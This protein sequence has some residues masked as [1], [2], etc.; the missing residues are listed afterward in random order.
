MKRTI[1]LTLLLSLAINVSVSAQSYSQVTKTGKCGKDVEWTLT[2][3]T[4]MI[5][6]A[7]TKLQL[8]EIADYD[9]ERAVAPWVKQKLK[10]TKVIIGRDIKRIGSCAFANCDELLT[11]EFE[12]VRLAEIGWGAFYNCR[13]LYQIS[14]PVLIKKIE[15]VAFANCSSIKSVKIPSLAYVEDNAFASCTNLSS[16]DI[17]SDVFLGNNVF[18]TEVEENG[19]MT[20]KMYNKDIINLPSNVNVDNCMEFGLSPNAVAVAKKRKNHS[21]EEE[22][23]RKSDVDLLIP[24][25]LKTRNDTYALVIGNQNYRFVPEVPFAINDALTFVQYCKTTLGIPS[26]NI[27]YCEDATKHMILELELE[28]WLKKDVPDKENKKLIV[29]YAG[30]GVPDINDNNKAYLLPTDVYGTKAYLGISLDDFYSKIGKMGFKVVTI[31]LDACFSGVN[32]NNEGL[33]G[34]RAVEIEAQ[35][36]RPTE[37]NLIVFSAAHGNETAQG[38]QEQGHGLFTYYL[39]KELKDSRGEISYGKLAQNLKKN[40]ST[41]APFLN[42]RKKQTPTTY[43]S[44]GAGSWQ[45]DA[46]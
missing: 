32:R 31:F 25:G 11:V 37:G 46:F 42:L 27:H 6:K 40:V 39:L 29:Y 23:L 18:V 34:E 7:S 38:F 33:A 4:L 24:E 21:D 2:G 36:S 14:I 15:T 41:K 30:H 16:I 45:A 8:V 20:K 5:K 28:D 3:T 13:K 35:E 19:K 22:L 1:L 12:D 43:S 9:M 44:F 10:I 26:E 17:A